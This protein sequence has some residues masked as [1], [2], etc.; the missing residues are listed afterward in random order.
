MIGRIIEVAQ[1]FLG[2]VPFSENNVIEQEDKIKTLCQ[3]LVTTSISFVNLCAEWPFL[4]TSVIAPK[5]NK[6]GQY[7]GY[8]EGPSN[9]LRVVKFA[10]SRLD[11]FISNNVFLYKG[12]KL[13][14]ISYFDSLKINNTLQGNEPIDAS[15]ASYKDQFIN[16]C[17]LKLAFQV[18]NTAWSDYEF[19]RSLEGA[20]LRQVKEVSSII[21]DRT[22]ITNSG[23]L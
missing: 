22:Y 13:E 21:I 6:S 1:T 7:E 5:E 23:R 11:C 19:T 2:S 17:A 10:P 16:L 8:I 12:G 14:Y 4:I 15:F 3:T 9:I 20:F 18:A